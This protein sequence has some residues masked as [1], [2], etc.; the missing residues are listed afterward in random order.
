MQ[1]MPDLLPRTIFFTGTSGTH[2]PRERASKIFS[3]KP[4]TLQMMTGMSL[5]PI[6]HTNGG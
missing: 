6:C 5:I 1:V 3:M 4:D 2:I